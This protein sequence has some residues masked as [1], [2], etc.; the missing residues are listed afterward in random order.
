MWKTAYLESQVLSANPLELI[1]LLYQHAIESVQSARCHLRD[2]EIVRRSK[3]VCRAIDSVSELDVA[4]NHSVGGE[5]S[6]NLAQLYGYIRQRLT[7]GNMRQLD[8]PLMEAESLLTTLAEGWNGVRA[9]S[10]DCES[11]VEFAPPAQSGLW[12]QTQAGAEHRWEA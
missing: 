9:E 6:Q 12:Q 1:R 8:G 4:L 11:C 7:E 2:G 10:P 5:V 3:A